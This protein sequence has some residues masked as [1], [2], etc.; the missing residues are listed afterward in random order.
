MRMDLG[1]VADAGS[2]EAETVDRPIQIGRPVTLAQGKSFPQRCL[3]DLDRLAARRFQVEYLVADRQRDLAAT[4][5]SGL[6]VAHETPVEDR[7]RTGQHAFDRLVGQ[8]LSIAPPIDRH[9]FGP[10]NI[11]V[12]DRRS[13]A[14]RPVALH[15]AIHGESETRKLL[16]E[17]LDHVVALEFA[18]DQHVEPG[19]FLPSDRALGFLVQES[20]VALTVQYAAIILGAGF[21]HGAGLRKGPDGGCR[22]ER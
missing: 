18:M 11:A 1:L 10:R 20:V 8:P 15:P 22:E 6:I 7:D 17:I 2:R 16:A 14:A 13:D 4:R 5:L 12:K 3:I 19:L 9:R 21:A